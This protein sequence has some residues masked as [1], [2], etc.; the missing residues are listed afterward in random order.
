MPSAKP[1]TFSTVPKFALRPLE[2]EDAIGSQKLWRAAVKAGWIRPRVKAAKKCT[3]YSAE[4]VAKLWE[5][6]AGGD[7]PPGFNDIAN[8]SNGGPPDL[9][10]YG[11]GTEG[12]A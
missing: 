6:I 8:D 1:N 5:R 11:Y 10:D 9:D 7:I 12:A 4:D 3:L 2:A